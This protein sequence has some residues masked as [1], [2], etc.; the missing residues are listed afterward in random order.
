MALND[1]PRRARSAFTFPTTSWAPTWA[2]PWRNRARA[3]TGRDGPSIAVLGNCQARGVAQAMRLLAPKSPVRY[4]PMGSLKRD[5]GHIDGLVRTLL[6]HDH[7]F[8]QTFPAGL[9]PGGDAATLRAADP[10]LKLFPSIVFSAF[11]PDMVYAGQAS[12]LAALKLAPS[13]MGQYH[14]A[15]VLT[16]H[17]LGLAPERTA[18]LFREDVFRRLGYLDHWDPAVRELVGA[19]EAVGFGLE[20]ELTRW[21]RRG[22]F[23][24][25][26]NHPKAHVVGD[27]ARRLLVESGIAPEP[28]EIEDYLGDELTQDVIWP[29]Y[30][31]VAEQF[32]LTGSYL[33]KAKAAKSKV[34][35]EAFPVLYDLPGFIAASFSI[36]DALPAGDLTCPRVE[37]WLAAP[38]IVALFRAG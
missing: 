32:G 22:A 25:L 30:P 29:I 34:V 20:R 4:L 27:I 12:D 6:A 8:S 33:F 3:V 24:H 31:A 16:A 18:A 11:H 15:I 1:L 38:A 10:R 13:P 9:I 36:Y 37:T 7:V 35:G 17:R 19:A 28:V 2:T 26:M 14:S 21:A 23:M 5:H